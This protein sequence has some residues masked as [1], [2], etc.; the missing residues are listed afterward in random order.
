MGEE[1]GRKEGRK[2]G[3]T[4]REVPAVSLAVVVGEVAEVGL[5]IGSEKEGKASLM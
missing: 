5:G 3:R 1:G 4:K 2:E